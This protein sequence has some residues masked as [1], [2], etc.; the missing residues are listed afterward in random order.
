MRTH[1]LQVA[2]EWDIRAWF[3]LGLIPLRNSK[4]TLVDGCI[5]HVG[6]TEGHGYP[7]KGSLNKCALYDIDKGSWTDVPLPG[8]LDNTPKE[9]GVEK[10]R[11][12]E[13][14]VEESVSDES[15]SESESGEESESRTESQ[16]GDEGSGSEGTGVVDG[17][18]DQ[19]EESE[20]EDDGESE[21]E[22]G[23]DIPTV[24]LVDCN[25]CLAT[26]C[27]MV[28]L[29]VTDREGTLTHLYTYSPS[30]ERE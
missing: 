2:Y 28:Y 24:N 12:G 20:Y 8:A 3:E 11:E 9:K 23:E 14:E 5:F 27:D 30:L 1:Q 21:S 22:E 4:S 10:E 18:E 25:Y 17:T 16:Y 19:S 29:F 26:V 13:A 6:Y 7:T 15:E